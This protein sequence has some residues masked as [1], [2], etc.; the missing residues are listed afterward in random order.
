MY[1]PKSSSLVLRGGAPLNNSETIEI[2]VGLQAGK[3]MVRRVE[4]IANKGLSPPGWSDRVA[5]LF[6]LLAEVGRALFVSFPSGHCRY[7]I[8]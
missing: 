6:Y 2:S 5:K 7:Q 8:P 3:R 4:N 1:T